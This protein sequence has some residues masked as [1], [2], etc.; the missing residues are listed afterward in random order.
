MER[1]FGFDDYYKLQD[2]E[3]LLCPW[4]ESRDRFLRM[5]ESSIAS[6]APLIGPQ[7]QLF[8]ID[9]NFWLRSMRKKVKQICCRLRLCLCFVHI[10]SSLD[11]CLSRNRSRSEAHEEQN[12]MN[13]TEE[14]IL[15]MNEHFEPPD[16]S[17]VWWERFTLCLSS[18][19][20]DDL[21]ADPT[22][23]DL[24]IFK[25]I[26]EFVDSIVSSPDSLPR[27]LQRREEEEEEAKR[28]KGMESDER[29]SCTSLKHVFDLRLRNLISEIFRDIQFQSLPESRKKTIGRSV[30]QEK[31]RFLSSLSD[32]PRWF[33][34]FCFRLAL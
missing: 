22:G 11:L 30:S 19:H 29:Q 18:N 7:T 9:D 15:R 16:G 10:E 23:S 8:V 21:V 24:P 3:A 25:M 26:S 14:T 5:I 6:T 34:F 4:S 33:S 13:V 2:A 17:K 1:V 32:F 27:V 31:Q 28:R 12:Q 20:L